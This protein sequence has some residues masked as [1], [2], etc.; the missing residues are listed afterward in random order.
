MATNASASE[1]ATDATI[2]LAPAYQ[3]LGVDRE[4]FHHVLDRRRD[5]VHRVD[6]LAAKRERVT[7]LRSDKFGARGNAVE[8]YVHEFVGREIGWAD[9]TLTCRDIFGKA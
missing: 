3:H 6:P 4:G 9:R 8:C 5:V 1:N 7:D 2:R